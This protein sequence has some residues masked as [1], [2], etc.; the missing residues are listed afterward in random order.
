MFNFGPALEVP[1]G[2]PVEMFTRPFHTRSEMC[3][4]IWATSISLGGNG[5][6][7]EQLGS[8]KRPK[9]KPVT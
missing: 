1:V 5:I 6:K 3:R 9:E 4:R 2:S 7:E 8:E